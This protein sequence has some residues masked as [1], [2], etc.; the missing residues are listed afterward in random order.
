[1]PMIAPFWVLLA[2]LQS[3]DLKPTRPQELWPVSITGWVTLV[4]STLALAVVLWRANNKPVLD[5]LTLIEQ[6]FDG[7]IKRI[8]TRL[9]NVDSERV[10]SEARFLT[11]INDKINGFGA[12]VEENK[13][14]IVFL[15]SQ[16]VG[17]AERMARSE[18]D[19]ATINSRLA[20]IENQTDSTMRALPDLELRLTNTLHAQTTTLLRELPEMIQKAITAYAQ[21]QSAHNASGTKR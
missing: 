2:L 6:K 3:V 20:G 16:Q 12:R 10:A 7:E 19:R 13:E 11:Q 14:N 15:S 5:R 9:D 1:M 17:F 8:E 21:L 4:S 18:M